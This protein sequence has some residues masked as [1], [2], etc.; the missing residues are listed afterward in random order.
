MKEGPSTHFEG[1][2]RS[3]IRGEVIR[4]VVAAIGRCAAR[5]PQDQ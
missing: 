1:Y 4:K 2:L 3:K 5:Q